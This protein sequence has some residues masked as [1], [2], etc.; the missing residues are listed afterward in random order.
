MKFIRITFKYG[1]GSIGERFINSNL[2]EQ[3]NGLILPEDK[4]HTNSKSSLSLS[5]GVCLTCLEPPA[6]IVR[7]I[8][9]AD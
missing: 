8:L 9:S 4:K 6:E 2:I 3:I 5:S 1:D 7:Q